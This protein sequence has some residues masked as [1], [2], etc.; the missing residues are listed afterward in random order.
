MKLYYITLPK[1]KTLP[2][3]FGQISWKGGTSDL[4]TIDKARQLMALVGGHLTEVDMGDISKDE[5]QLIIANI[6]FVRQALTEKILSDAVEECECGDGGSCDC[7][8]TILTT[9]ADPTDDILKNVFS[10]IDETNTLK[11]HVENPS[12][13]PVDPP[14]LL[15]DDITPEA[16]V[17]L[18]EELGIEFPAYNKMRAEIGAASADPGIDYD[19]YAITGGSREMDK[20]QKAWLYLQLKLREG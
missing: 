19:A 7:E 10:G 6:D 18:A 4:I 15:P 12:Q 3:D 20:I 1:G 16:V 11:E 17:N 5:L 13:V 9:V 14:M 8:D 2:N